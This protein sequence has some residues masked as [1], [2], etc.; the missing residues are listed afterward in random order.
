M[1]KPT[2]SKLRLN[3]SEDGTDTPEEQLELKSVMQD[4]DTG[5]A[6][7]IVWTDSGLAYHQGWEQFRE[8]TEKAR[9]M[10]V[11]T[12]GIWMGENDRVVMVAHS[13]DADN[14]NWNVSM[15]LYKPCII[16]KEWL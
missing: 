3:R 1:T 10:D 9:V 8:A 4:A 11:E 15:T 2:P 16:R 7:R 12:V 13:R 5:R 14:E 6:V